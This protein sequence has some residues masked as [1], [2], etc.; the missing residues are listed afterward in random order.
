MNKYFEYKQK[1]K[2]PLCINNPYLGAILRVIVDLEDR[3][4][5]D[6]ILML[7]RIDVERLI[8]MYERDLK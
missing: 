7:G 5:D 6:N 4:D 3:I 2:E 8:E 1:L